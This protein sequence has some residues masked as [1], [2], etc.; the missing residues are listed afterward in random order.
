MEA[1]IQKLKEK[2]VRDHFDEL[3]PNAFL[4]AYIK[5][6]FPQTVSLASQEQKKQLER[7]QM[8]AQPINYMKKPANGTSFDNPASH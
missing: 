4:N 5:S 2:D 1:K 8:P 3:Q 7:G 6:N